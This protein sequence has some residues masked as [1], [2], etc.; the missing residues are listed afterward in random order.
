MKKVVMVLV[1]IGLMLSFSSCNPPIGF[2][3]NQASQS[4]ESPRGLIIEAQ[5]K[6]DAVQER[7]NP[8]KV[9]AVDKFTPAIQE[10][11]Q[12]LVRYDR[13][14]D[15]DRLVYAVEVFK[16]KYDIFKYDLK[17]ADRYSPEN[18]TRIVSLLTTIRDGFERV[19]DMQSRAP[20]DLFNTDNNVL[21]IQHNLPT[22]A[23]AG[24]INRI[25]EWEKLHTIADAYLDDLVGVFND[26]TSAIDSFLII[27]D[28]PKSYESEV[29]GPNS[30]GVSVLTTQSKKL[31]E[32]AALYT[33]KLSKI[34][35]DY[36]AYDLLR[37]WRTYYDVLDK[38]QLRL[39]DYKSGI[40]DILGSPSR[41][42]ISQLGHIL[43][44]NAE[45]HLW[46]GH[47]FSMH[48]PSILFYQDFGVYEPH[49]RA[50]EE[51]FSRHIPEEQTTT[52]D[53]ES[54]EL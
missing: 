48:E 6:I 42:L 51:L 19:Q 13:D 16:M 24:L 25:N 38:R 37:G 21:G 4:S 15:L 44:L 39:T 9:A 22:P 54:S 32:I 53:H 49:R 1:I 36:S 14:N 7:G 29:Y 41:P 12:A 2:T 26:I 50:V 46:F 40:I 47:E 33:C 5:K 35:E 23:S 52:S 3:D 28:E 34:K 27:W 18:L 31:K 11:K 10:L 17:M 8:Q 30:Y 20:E 43:P 45:P